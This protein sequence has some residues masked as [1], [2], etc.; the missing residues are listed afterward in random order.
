[1][2]VTVTKKDGTK[3]TYIDVSLVIHDGSFVVIS[4]PTS[5]QDKMINEDSIEEVDVNYE[6]DEDSIDWNIGMSDN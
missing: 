5:K 2:V 4:S 1:M 3:A 6:A